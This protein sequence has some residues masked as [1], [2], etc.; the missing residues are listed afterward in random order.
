MTSAPW[1][2]VWPDDRPA[3]PLRA[4]P[5]E[6]AG[7]ELDL[8]GVTTRQG[9]AQKRAWLRPLVSWL[10]K[11]PHADLEDII[12]ATPG[13]PGVESVRRFLHRL[14]D[15]GVAATGSRPGSTRDTWRIVNK[16]RAFLMLDKMRAA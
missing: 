6:D 1:C 4:A 8:S 12:D 3:L 13:R 15:A 5:V 11:N 14:K 9:R 10:A 2:Y 16:Q 7:P